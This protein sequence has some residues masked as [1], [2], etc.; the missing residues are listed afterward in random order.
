MDGN[1]E[2][3]NDLLQINSFSKDDQVLFC[4]DNS[5]VTLL[6]KSIEKDDDNN[7]LM[8]FPKLIYQLLD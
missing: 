2:T 1:P 4:T 7:R 6:N 5:V 3:T 8:F